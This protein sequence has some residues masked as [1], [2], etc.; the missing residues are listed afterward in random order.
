VATA[1]AALLRAAAHPGDALAQGH[2]A[3][4]PLH[5]LLQQDG[6]AYP[7]TVTRRVLGAVQAR[8]FEAW[9]E[10]WAARL[11]DVLPANDRFSRLRLRQLAQA[12]Q[13]FD[14]TGSRDID[15]FLRFLEAQT[16]RE[17]EGAGVVRVMTIH[18]SKGLGFDVVV[19]PDLQGQK[20]A[21]RRSGP[22]VRKGADRAIDWVLEYPGEL[23]A[24]HDPVLRDYLREAVAENCYEQLSL[25]YV[26]LTRAKHATYAVVEPPGKSVSLNFPRLLTETLGDA[27]MDV[28]VGTTTLRG[29]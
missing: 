16:V 19:L 25:L 5:A 24:A 3:M 21:Q 28:Q 27:E 13:A 18:K 22:A 15:A 1:L 6:D 10:D 23:V 14:A 17:P 9:F 7:E 2:V 29:A 26:A 20:L 12:G 4:S 8:G 11:E